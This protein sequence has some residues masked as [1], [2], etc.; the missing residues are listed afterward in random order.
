METHTLQ[1]DK[2][3][4]ARLVLIP[5]TLLICKNFINNDFSDLS[6]MGLKKGKGWPDIDVLETLP[7]IVDNL[8][9]VKAPTG[10]ESWMIV[11][12][13]TL[14]IIG[15]LGFKGF[16]YEEKNIDLGYGIIKKER[17][18]GYAKE[19]T[20]ELI[21]WAFSNEIVKEITARCLIDNI[22]SVNLLKKLNFKKIKVNDTMAFWSLKNGKYRENDA[23]SHP[24]LQSGSPI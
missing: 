4:T 1:I 18:K 7:K 14:E 16:N 6:S 11:K 21:K 19:A 17:Q 8:S 13:D 23:T 5:F 10:F 15:D 3:F 2:I 22:S 20:T 12:K 9:R 24:D